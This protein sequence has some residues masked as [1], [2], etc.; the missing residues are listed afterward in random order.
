MGGGAGG[1]GTVGALPPHLVLEAHPR[2]ADVGEARTD[3]EHVVVERRAQVAR[4]DLDDGEAEALGL[5][6]AIRAAAPAQEVGP[7]H[8]EP[9]QILAVPGDAHLV[10]LRVA[11]AH[12]GGARAA[13]RAA[14]SRRRAAA[15]ASPP[16]NTD[17]PATSTSAPAST[18][19]FALLSSTPPST[20]IAVA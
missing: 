4:L 14:S 18:S 6:L 17:V 10:G 20:S 3:L 7:S 2:P 8:L 9:G 16:S 15:V 1:E 5:Q 11:H 13:H 19:A 12:R